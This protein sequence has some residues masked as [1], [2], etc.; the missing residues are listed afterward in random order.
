MIFLN[1]IKT[2]K[3]LLEEAKNLQ[4]DYE[5]Y[6]KRIRKGNKSTEQRKT[7]ANINILFHARNNAIKFIEDYGSM[8]LDLKITNS[9]CTNK[10]R[11]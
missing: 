11:Q 10:S 6:L 5:A 2:G 3:I 9:S 4:Q 7:L 1:D 8:I